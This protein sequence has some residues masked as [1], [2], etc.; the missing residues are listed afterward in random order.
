LIITREQIDELVAILRQALIMA[1]RDLR[2][3]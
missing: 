2:A 3:A 1:E